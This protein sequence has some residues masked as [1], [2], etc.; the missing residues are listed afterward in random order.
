MT[1][2]LHTHLLPEMDDGCASLEESLLLLSELKKQGV[3]AVSLTPHFYADREAPETFFSRREAAFR[4]LSEALLPDAP[5]LFC[6]AEVW[7]YSGIS[8]TEKPEDFAIG[9]TGLFLL[10]LP[11]ENWTDSMA[12][13]V[14]AI[15]RHRGIRVVLAHI[16]R[17]LSFLDPAMLEEF[18]S[19][20]VLLQANADSFLERKTQKKVLSLL[21]NGM[22]HF[23][24]SDCHDAAVRRPRL[25]EAYSVIR[26]K[27]GPGAVKWLSD[28]SK[29]FFT[30]E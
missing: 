28:Y 29:V 9:R 15:H 16:D 1:A 22:I 12:R 24:A 21:K 26:K 13:E 7:Y 2:D 10:E 8:G 14:L 19:E 20:G 30:G 3:S 5:A 4:R 6:G 17:Y 25:D 23:V 27:L 18:C 11:F